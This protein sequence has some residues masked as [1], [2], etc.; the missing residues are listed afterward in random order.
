MNVFDLLKSDH[1]E[2]SDLF[3]KIE[4]MPGKG[5]R[6]DDLFEQLKMQ[7]QMHSDVEEE[8]FYPAL[9]EA[10][11]THDIVLE[12]LEEHDVVKKLLGELDSEP[13]YTDEWMAK[14]TVLRENVEHH[15]EEEETRLFPKAGKLLT[16][17]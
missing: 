17:D 12:S 4:K 8:I 5:S 15:V 13:K 9:Q 3:D 10:A 6:K 16:E 2:V 11:E 14:L 7:L 1:R